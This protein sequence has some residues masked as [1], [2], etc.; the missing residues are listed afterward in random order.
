MRMK[1]IAKKLHKYRDEILNFC[2]H[3][4][5]IVIYGTGWV[6]KAVF[7]YLAEEEIDIFA[8]CVS[9][10]RVLEDEFCDK[11]VYEL[12][13]F[14]FKNNDGIILAVGVS[15]QGEIISELQAAQFPLKDIYVQQIYCR[16]IDPQIIE[17]C[18]FEK[19]TTAELYFGEYTCLD[20]LGQKYGTD[21]SSKVHD[22]LRKY[23]F[24]LNKWKNADINVLELGI[25]EG[26]SLN[27]W[28]EYFPNATIYGVDITEECTRFEGENRKVLIQD[29]S[30][31]NRLAD[32]GKI[33]PSIII[34]DASHF[35]SHQIKALYQ[36]LPLLQN[37]GVYILEDLGTSFS[38]YRN[39]N[40]DDA[41]ISAY[42]FCSA[43]AE[44]VA[45]G[46]MLRNTHL[47][48]VLQSLKQEIEFLAQQISMISFIHE[49]CIIV[50]K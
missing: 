50:K 3:H 27:M 48:A 42:D 41:S 2:S 8:F 45:S 47:R 22:Y 9:D 44:V 21:K 43:I 32:L 25:L 23:E 6:G 46:E 29:L 24:F 37:G 28:G 35:W 7:Q 17:A 5:R 38:S 4:S 16:N 31:E 40:Y 39:M 19:S 30:D 18:L 49:S 34:D 26:G 33:H 20:K 14:S 10:D 11:K 36:L 15:L 13:K 12:G 1:R